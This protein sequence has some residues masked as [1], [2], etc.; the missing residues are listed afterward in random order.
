M[1]NWLISFRIVK[2]YAWG[3][4]F[5]RAK[6][7]YIST[8]QNFIVLLLPRI[9]CITINFFFTSK[10][11]SPHNC[12]IAWSIESQLEVHILKNQIHWEHPTKTLVIVLSISKSQIFFLTEQCFS[13]WLY[14]FFPVVKKIVLFILLLSLLTLFFS[15][16]ISQ[17]LVKVT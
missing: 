16:I 7:N 10:V 5:Y 4:L 13:F 6:T 11:P 3:Y 8:R 17:L 14:T 1:E 2:W 12:K 15:L 9:I